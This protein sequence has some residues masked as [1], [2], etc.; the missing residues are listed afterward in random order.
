MQSTV[1][2]FDVSLLAVGLIVSLNAALA[3]FAGGMHRTLAFSLACA[4]AC[5]ATLTLLAFRA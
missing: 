3:A 1:N 2:V 5:T 4:I